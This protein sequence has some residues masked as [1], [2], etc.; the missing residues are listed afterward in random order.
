MHLLTSLSLIFIYKFLNLIFYCTFFFFLQ[1]QR[2][3]TRQ[4]DEIQTLKRQL[5]NRERRIR[6]LEELVRKLQQSQIKNL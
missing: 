2:T 1:L 5:A 4:Q 3:F 6:E